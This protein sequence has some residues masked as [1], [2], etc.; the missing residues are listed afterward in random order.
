MENS[1]FEMDNISECESEEDFKNMDLYSQ[2]LIEI[3]NKILK[4]KKENTILN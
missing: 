3:H 2:S 4:L 1:Y